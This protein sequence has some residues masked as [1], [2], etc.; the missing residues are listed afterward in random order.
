MHNT[1]NNI[2]LYIIQLDIQFNIKVFYNT[3]ILSKPHN[4]EQSIYVI[5]PLQLTLP[6]SNND[7]YI[8]TI[9]IDIY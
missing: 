6:P 7:I 9:N 2:T 3:Y 8:Y 4:Y 1:Y 5:I